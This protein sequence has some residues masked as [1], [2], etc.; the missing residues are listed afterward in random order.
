MLTCSLVPAMLASK[1]TR[2]CATTRPL[3]KQ[4]SSTVRLDS[5]SG[6]QRGSTNRKT[7]DV[8]SGGSR[9]IELFVVGEHRGPG[10]A[11]LMAARYAGPDRCVGRISRRVG[12]DPLDTVA[13]PRHQQLAA[14]RRLQQR[15][16]EASQIRRLEIEENGPDSHGSA[17]FRRG[18]SD[19]RVSIGTRR[20]GSHAPKTMR[21]SARRPLPLRATPFHGALSS[22]P[23]D[24]VPT[25]R[26]HSPV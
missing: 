24:G 15:P 18:R 8:S 19:W 17:S 23:A 12:S 2:W 25:V 7:S 5:S 6:R 10:H 21:A 3:W 4:S 26:S 11:A 9:S 14:D 22:R 1:A 20:L 13:Q 16:S